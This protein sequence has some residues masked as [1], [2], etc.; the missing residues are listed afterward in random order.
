[1]PSNRH[2]T[3]FADD[4]GD[5]G[6]AGTEHF[7]YA[8]L[9]VERSNMR[10]ITQIAA[11]FRVKHEM[12][13]EAKAW[14]GSPR[15]QDLISKVS[16][17]CNSGVILTGASILRKANYQ[18]PYL[19]D[20]AQAPR[21]PHFLRNFCVRHALEVLFADVAFEERDTLELVLDRVEY[22]DKQI[23]NLRDYLNSVYAK[24]GAFPFPR[25][26][27]VTHASSSYVEGLQIAHHLAELAHRV[28]MLADPDPAEL[29]RAFLRIKT[30]VS[31]RDFVLDPKA[32]EGMGREGRG[33]RQNE[34][35][36]PESTISAH[37]P[38]P[39]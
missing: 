20:T 12:F 16:S 24:E 36:G 10:H 37:P 1:M 28:H 33:V 25:L 7:G 6:A 30:L 32:R 34:E 39:D 9:A 38:P 22:S 19:R 3:A 17:A 5:P 2:W 15:F 29:A 4:T 35:R 31:S 13:L 26:K 27:H 8:V 23:L 18:G 21:D 14:I 11:E